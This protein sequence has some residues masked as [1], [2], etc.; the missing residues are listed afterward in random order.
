VAVYH[1]LAGRFSWII[2]KF[3]RS[4]DAIRDNYQSRV[5]VFSIYYPPGPKPTLAVGR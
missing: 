5:I 4:N 1:G 3:E 2:L